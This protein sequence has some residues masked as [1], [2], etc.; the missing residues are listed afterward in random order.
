MSVTQ[1]HSGSAFNVIPETATLREFRRDPALPCAA[2]CLPHRA[3]GFAVRYYMVLYGDATRLCG[4]GAKARRLT[5]AHTVARAVWDRTLRLTGPIS[6]AVARSACVVC[7]VCC[8]PCVCSLT[9]DPSPCLATLRTLHAMLGGTVRA[10][11]EDT[12]ARLEQV[13][14]PHPPTPC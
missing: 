1:F 7:G 4:A 3:T 12:R 13:I 11:S 2:T 6:C 14:P 5:S 8:A 10:F 9:T